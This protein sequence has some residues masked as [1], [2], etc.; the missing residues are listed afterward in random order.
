MDL[1]LLRLH[2]QQIQRQCQAAIMAGQQADQGLRDRNNDM[3]WAGIQNLLNAAANISKA[4]WGQGGKLTGAR[5]PLRDSLGIDD[6]NPIANTDL[7]NHLEHYDE[8]LDKWFETST[9]HNSIEV[10]GPPNTVV[11]VADADIFRWF[12]PNSL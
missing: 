11:G 10:I 5:K 4:C 9:S 12:D 6:S 1:M 2:Q 3:F 8:R 7:R